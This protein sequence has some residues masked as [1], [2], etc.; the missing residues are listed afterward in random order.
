[1]MFPGRSVAGTAV[2]IVLF[3]DGTDAVSEAE[4]DAVIARAVGWVF[5]SHTSCRR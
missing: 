2:S 5:Q 4:P 3:T 1:M